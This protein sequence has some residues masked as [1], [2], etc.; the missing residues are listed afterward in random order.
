MGNPTMHLNRVLYNFKEG[1]SLSDIK[2]I[3][4]LEDVKEFLAT[5]GFDWEDECCIDEYY[6]Y[7]FYGNEAF[8]N[9]KSTFLEIEAYDSKENYKINYGRELG[10][11]DENRKVILITKQKAM[12]L[13]K[14]TLCECDHLFKNDFIIND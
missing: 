11:D 6:D 12:E 2:D 7:N 9:D 1:T 5:I 8:V 14:N 3:I 13:F 10:Y 4:K